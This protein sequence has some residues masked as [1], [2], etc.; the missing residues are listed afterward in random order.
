MRV[1]LLSDGR[2]YYR[3]ASNHLDILLWLFLPGSSLLVD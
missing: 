3:I 1:Q 2:I